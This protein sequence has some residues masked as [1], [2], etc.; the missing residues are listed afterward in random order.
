MQPTW[1]TRKIIRLPNYDY[2]ADGAYFI[3][4]CIHQRH[5]FLGNI[6]QDCMQL[7][8]AGEMVQSYWHSIPAYYSGV[9]LDVFQ[10]M[11]NHIHGILFLNKAQFSLSNLINRFKTITTRQYINEVYQ[12][13][14][15]PFNGK[16]WQRSYYENILRDEDTLYLTRE[17]IV[18]NPANWHKDKMFHNNI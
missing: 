8:E 5:C 11:P 13:N 7:N 2:S 10:V 18:N 16:L 9:S 14:W 15:H 6:V 17:Y 12:N 3:T 4:I 1:P